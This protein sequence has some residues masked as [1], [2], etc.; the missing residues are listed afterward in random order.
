MQKLSDPLDAVESSPPASAPGDADAGAANAAAG[1]TAEEKRALVAK[2]LLATP[3]KSNRQIAAIVGVTHKVVA[4]ARGK[5]EAAGQLVRPTS[6]SQ[7]RERKVNSHASAPQPLPTEPNVRQVQLTTAED[8][9]N[10]EAIARLS[11]RIWATIPA[12]KIL[13]PLSDLMDELIQSPLIDD[14][15]EEE[16]DENWLDDR[17]KREKK[18]LDEAI[19][20][21]LEKYPDI[22][23]INALPPSSDPDI[24]R[25]AEELKVRL[26]QCSVGA[27]EFAERPRLQLERLVKIELE[28]LFK[29]NLK[30]SEHIRTD[31]PGSDIKKY[32]KRR[33][34]SSKGTFYKSAEY[35]EG[36][37]LDAL[38]TNGW[39]RVAKERIDPVA[40]SHQY[41]MKRKTERQ[42]WRQ[43]FLI[44]ERNGVQSP[45]E[46]PRKELAG[47]GA[48]AIRSLMTAGVRVV[49]G[50]DARKALIWFL[51]FHP[52]QE[53]VRMPRVGWAQVGSHW[54]FARSDEVITPPDMPQ[55]HYTT[56]VLD[57]AVTQHGLHVAGAT[58]EWMAEIAAPLRG[59]SNV[60]LSLGTFFAAPMLRFASEPGGGHHFCGRSTIG[61]TM[62]SAVGQSIYGWPFETADDNTFGVSWGGS[63]AGS[64]AFL[65][66]R[67]DLGI[68]LDE[69]TRADPRKAEEIVYA[70]ASGTRGP[71]A[72]STG[73]LRETPHV[74]VLVLSTGEKSLVQFIGKTLQEGARKRLVDV[75]AEVQPDSAYETISDDRIHDAG[76]RLFDVM[77]LHHGAVGRDW[78][79]HLVVLGPDRLKAELQ[80]HREAFLALP[81]VVAVIRKAHPQVRA[82]VNR[83]ALNAAALRMAIEFSL[84]PW[85][86]EEADAG[87]V[88]CMHRWV[89]QRGNIDVAG[90]LVRAAD[91][92]I[93]RIK[94]A[95]AERF[96]TIR[97][98]KRVWEPVTEADKI[99]QESAAN[100]DGY[101]KPEH[102]LIRP[103]AFRRY[104]E[105]FDAD[106][107]AK[108]LQQQ[109]V[110]IPDSAGKRS[111]A[112]QIIGKIDRFVVLLLT[113][114]TP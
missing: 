83:F 107:I 66:A 53:I 80:K 5:L 19:T 85:A 90:E 28:K 84:L 34:T 60:A 29:K 27:T 104:C 12:E 10:R 48:S 3:E 87:I 49:A 46:L 72:K 76:K 22:D 58:A 101:V 15:D 47:N 16:T 114:L 30:Y 70:I 2:H 62:A 8:L 51:G 37:G 69:I 106:E 24:A 74:S 78:Q 50:D 75:P 41:G 65:Q 88:A 25:A 113:R 36:G 42:T 103:E 109:G 67:T 94:T 44:T 98:S 11:L 96:I 20:D 111:R 21:A 93:T 45:F 7:Q 52:P 17:H 57:A 100:F 38:L 97:K 105:G 77:K 23:S 14:D 64:A 68:A 18:L 92:A 40:W 91:E 55:A 73:Q 112:E 43:H 26:L 6:K 61:K 13:S 95:L 82:V 110:L 59:N 81:D 54:I 39:M 89:R 99:K 32:G 31:V 4:L 9:N 102:V 35:L 1:L 33:R 79:R 108:C 86:I 63:E 71:R 56:Y